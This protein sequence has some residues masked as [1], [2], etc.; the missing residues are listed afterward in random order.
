MTA[1]KRRCKFDLKQIESF[2]ASFDRNCPEICSTAFLDVKQ[3]ELQRRW[4]KLTESYEEYMLEDKEQQEEDA[5]DEVCLRYEGACDLYEST[6]IKILEKR[7]ALTSTGQQQ[8]SFRP[9]LKLPACEIQNFEGGYSR[10]PAFRDMFQAVIGKDPS[11]SPAQKLYYLRSKVRGEAYQAIKDLDLVDENFQ[12][13]W[14]KLKNRFENRRLLVQDQVKKINAITSAQNENIKSLRQIQNTVSDCLAIL[15]NYKIEF[16]DYDP[17][18]IHIVVSKLSDE[19]IKEWEVSLKNHRELPTW[20]QLNGFLSE[21]IEILETMTDRKKPF[22]KEAQFSR[23]QAFYIQSEQTSSCKK[24]KQ[25]HP[26][27]VCKYFKSLSPSER[28]KFVFANKYCVNCLSPTHFKS[29]CLSTNTCSVCHKKHHTMLHLE[30]SENSKHCSVS[31][32]HSKQTSRNSDKSSTSST[33][34]ETSAFNTQVENSSGPD[35]NIRAFLVRRKGTTVLPTALIHIEN[36]GELFTV[37]AL[38][39]SGAEKSFLTTRIQQKLGIPLEKHPRQISGFGGTIVGISK[40]KCVVT[41]KSRVSDFKLKILTVVTPKI[42]NFLPSHP[43]ELQNYAEIQNLTLADP[44]FY[45]PAVIDMIIGSDFLPFINLEGVRKNISGDL[46]ARESHFGWYLSGPVNTSEINAFSTTVSASENYRLHDQIKRFWE[47]EEVEKDIL[48]TEAD[49]FCENFYQSSTTRRADG[50][51]VVRLPF[52]EQFPKDIFLGPSKNSALGQYYRM[53]KTLEKTPELKESYRKVLQEYIDL[54]HMEPVFSQENNSGKQFSYFLP[55]HAVIRPE[56][57]STKVRVVFNASK[58]TNSGFSLNDVLYQGP[59]LQSDVMQVVLS[60]RYYKYVFTGDIEKMFR[61]IVMHEADR[62]YQQILFRNEADSF[63]KTFQMKT[64]TFGVNCAPFLAIRTLQQLSEDCKHTFPLASMILKNET[65]VDDILS[66]G[67][68]LEEARSK[69]SQI[70]QALNSAGFPLRKITANNSYLLNNLAREDLLDEDFLKFD[71][72]STIKTLGIRWNAKADFFYYVV[73]PN[74]ISPSPTKRQI[75]SIIAKLF[76]PLGWLGPIVVIA[77]LLMQEL[78]ELKTDW[79]EGVPPY[80]L[81]KWYT[82]LQNLP[83]IS[84]LRIPR[85][86]YFTPTHKIQIHGF[87]DSS[88]K[89]YCGAI[90][91]RTSTSHGEIN[92]NLLVAKTKIAP[93]KKTTIPKLELCGAVLLSK[94]AKGLM[95]NAKFPYELHLWTDSSIVLGWLQKPPRTLKTFVANRVI[96]IISITSN[97]HWKHVRTEDN[98]ADLGT[99]GCSPHELIESNLWWHGPTWLTQPCEYWPKP[100]E[101]DPIDLETKKVSTFHLKANLVNISR[102]N[103]ISHEIDSNVIIKRFSSFARMLRV[104]SYCFRFI[105]RIRKRLFETKSFITTKEIQFVK[106]RLIL[107]AQMHYFPREYECLQDKRPINRKSRLLTLTPFLDK[108]G[109]LRVGGRLSYSGLS[110]NER[111]PV[112]I[113]EKSYFAQLFVKYTHT[114]LLHAEHYIMLR[115]IRQGFYM[116]RLK[117]LVRKCIRNCKTCTVYKHKIQHQI[118]SAL[119]PERVNFSLP[120]TYTGV[121]FAGPFNLKSSNL[122]NAKLIKSYAAIFV[123]F[124]T[125]AVHLEVCSDLSTDAF[126][127]CFDRF[128][129]RRGFPKTMF[130]DNGRNFLGASLSLLKSHN[131]FLKKAEKTLVEKYSAHG[132]SWSFIPPYAPHM[133]GLWEAAVK[134]MKSHLK[135]VASNL[136]FTYEEFATIL[137]KIE[138]VLNSRPMSPLT[139]NPSEILPLTPGHFL[140]GAPI[141]APP[142]APKEPPLESVSFVKRW[143]RLKALQHIFARRWKNEYITEL[144]RRVKWK[145]EQHNI[146]LNDF[147]IVKDDLLPPTEWRLGRITKVIYGKDNKVRVAEIKTQNGTITRSI[148]KLCLLPTSHTEDNIPH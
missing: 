104:M 4:E 25:N 68:S 88:E 141:I 144:Q 93:I 121:D 29:K 3:Q 49:A 21:R 86:V 58:K 136:N 32:G 66:G 140:R 80:I 83:Q 24:C 115:A 127:A 102:K 5:K 7:E 34:T 27:K 16:P 61:Q 134:S 103:I 129:G 91:M 84:L 2:C 131:E 18:L 130:S 1:S 114:I 15:K 126:L 95:K 67:H 71:D 132:F 45:Q 97:S 14:N 108:D 128:V 137:I 81:A 23:T 62:S 107:I 6:K 113:P 146:K 145:S 100:R 101:F 105:D 12:L 9:T 110:Y 123:C 54:D 106:N 59:A 65:Y 72:S 53:E 8:S 94:L 36:S 120:F 125:R 31:T 142:E 11:V 38:L 116:P 109:L 64:V 119:P 76:D 135:K 138:A 96:K 124:S 48:I 43:I 33:Q 40:G 87:C 122:R 35:G 75:L 37:R 20:S 117:S 57:K 99:R 13:A 133:G 52:K 28:V 19:T 69:Q 74:Q 55:H 51:Y 46:E 77:K 139:E 22:P 111:Y 73:E 56:S 47:L 60:W 79:D 41:V 30:K 90:Y 143:E 39:D 148:A 92:C 26:L 118:M 112:I 42:A 78:W 63:V 82:F 44:Y 89:A 70:K 98:P 85:W 10:W 17:F 50:R 147:V